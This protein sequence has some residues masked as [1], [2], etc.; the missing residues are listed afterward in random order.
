LPRVGPEVALGKIGEY[1]SEVSR[2]R[3][4]QHVQ[5]EH[6]REVL[7]YKIIAFIRNAFDNPQETIKVYDKSCQYTF[8]N[9]R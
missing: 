9:C 2:L 6:Q 1:L 8:C 7:N 5:G 3:E 4:L